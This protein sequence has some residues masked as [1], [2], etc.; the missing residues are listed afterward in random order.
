MTGSSWRD[1]FDIPREVTYLNAAQI[2]PAP[3]PCLEAGHAAYNA[4]ARPWTGGVAEC[5]FD[6]PEALRT[7]GASL[8]KATAEDIALVPAASYGLAV[9]ARNLTLEPGQEILVLEGQFPS[10]VYTWRTLAQRTGARVRPVSRQESQ[11]WTQALLSAIGP[12][13]GLVACGA[14]HWIDGGR[15]DLEAVSK[16]VRARNAHLV[17][18]LTQSAGVMA[19]DVAKVD[20]DFAVTAC[21]KWLLGPYAIGLLYVAPRHQD[22]EPLEENWINRAGSE[23]FSRLIDYQD[24]YQ[25]GARRFDMGERSSHQLVP[26]ALASLE[27]L[28]GFGWDAIARHCAEMTSA[29]AEA[30]APFGL[31]DDTPERAGHYLSLGLPET[32]PSNLLAQLKADEV[33]VSQRGP[34]LRVTPHVYTDL[35]DVERFGAALKRIF[36]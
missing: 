1:A 25:P 32:T 8:F 21:Y 17:L 4:K 18:D 15:V 22:G 33:H 12:Q 6:A 10:N 28:T 35:H 14:V 27:T 13:T 36:A 16:A 2:G 31:V 20:P 19:F 11:T 29:L 3:R 26:A 34:R 30:A 9:A 7:A 23:D 5:F 24:R